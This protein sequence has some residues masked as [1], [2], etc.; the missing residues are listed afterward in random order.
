MW[1][2]RGRALLA[3]VFAA[4]EQRWAA[5][6]HPQ[7]AGG[8]LG[9][10]AQNF[11]AM[12]SAFTV[13]LQFTAERLSAAAARAA[14]AAA[15]SF[16]ATRLT[17]H[18]WH[19]WR[20]A[21]ADSTAQRQLQALQAT[22]FALW[23]RHT[24]DALQHPASLI[25]LRRALQAK[26]PACRT[27]QQWYERRDMKQSKGSVLLALGLALLLSAHLGPFPP[28]KYG[29]A[30]PLEDCKTDADCCGNQECRTYS[31]YP[32]LGDHAPYPD[33][34]VVGHKRCV[35][36]SFRH[37]TPT[38]DEIYLAPST[39]T[40][41]NETATLERI[42][43]KYPEFPDFDAWECSAG[44]YFDWYVPHFCCISDWMTDLFPPCGTEPF[45][46]NT[47]VVPKSLAACRK[48]APYKGFIL[49]KS[50]CCVAPGGI[51]AQDKYTDPTTGS[52][53]LI[54]IVTQAPGPGSD[55]AT[56]G[57]I[58]E[59]CPDTCNYYNPTEDSLWMCVKA[60]DLGWAVDA[61]GRWLKTA[62]NACDL[63]AMRDSKVK[64]SKVKN[65]KVF[66]CGV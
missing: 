58:K 60:S 59:C 27:E 9:Q 43:A 46:W 65:M 45:C 57:P 25:N 51:S 40:N 19:S 23:K 7:A 2:V 21:V 34:H 37:A 10:H 52:R 36:M 53:C 39:P 38:A 17:S 16:H 20:L 26:Y 63:K 62:A 54:G 49:N 18:A 22:C 1:P 12:H 44:D 61:A 29:T 41:P 50:G 5:A 35:P 32:N 8:V 56:W 30:L 48:I 3:R 28:V 55:E 24:R 64:G 31:A 14:A 66:D 15:A 47:D 4:A 13:W 6:G 11:T 42:S 33:M